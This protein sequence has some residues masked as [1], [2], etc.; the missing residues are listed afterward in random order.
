MLRK[1]YT[2]SVNILFKK[3]EFERLER[4]AEI[5]G[6]NRSSAVRT[7]IN[8]YCA[9]VLD[10]EPLCATGQRCF[11]PTYHSPP[12]TPAHQVVPVGGPPNAQN[13]GG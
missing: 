5:K 12:A 2:R 7:A 6:V 3:E 11:V 13:R 9:M 10:N 8:A 4:L 1:I